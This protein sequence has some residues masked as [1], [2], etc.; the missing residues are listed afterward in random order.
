MKSRKGWSAARIAFY[1]ARHDF[2]A[3]SSSISFH[4]S[5]CDDVGFYRTGGS[6]VF[7]LLWDATPE[8]VRSAC[9]QNLS[10]PYDIKNERW[11]VHFNTMGV[12]IKGRK[13]Q[14]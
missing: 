7:S 6:D 5:K 12:Q 8:A 11:A 2:R 9:T 13:G 3:M 1:Q 14:L 4:E 10:R